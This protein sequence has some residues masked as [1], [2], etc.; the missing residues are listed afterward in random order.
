[1][2][3]ATRRVRLR[4]IGITCSGCAMDMENILR[5]KEGILHVTVGY[6]DGIIEI[7]YD[8]EVTNLDKVFSAVSGLGFKT[9]ILS[10]S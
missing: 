6:S 8:P 2:G 7:R 5:D 9:R 4:T 10:E 1:M 3:N